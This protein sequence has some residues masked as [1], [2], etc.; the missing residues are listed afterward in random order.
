MYYD[1][2]KMTDLLAGNVNNVR[3][4]CDLVVS[5]EEPIA[6]LC[7]S[8]QEY[9]IN[10]EVYTNDMLFYVLPNRRATR[11][12]IMLTTAYVEWA[13]E[14]G[15]REVRLS[16]TTGIDLKRFDKFCEHIGFDRLGSIYRKEL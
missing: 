16:S 3:F 13:V 1:R 9:L 6:G 8:L 5:G 4:F 10:R 15:V 7:A 14:R 11:A 2:K 12:A